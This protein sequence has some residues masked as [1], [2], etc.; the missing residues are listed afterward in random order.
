MSTPVAVVPERRIVSTD[1]HVERRGEKRL[2]VISGYAARFNELAPEQWGFR[3]K[4]DPT[5]F[6]D[7]LASP[8]TDV[9][10]FFNHDNN[11]IVGRQSA[12][13]LRLSV[14]AKGLRYEIDPPD[15]QAGRDLVVSVE[16]GDVREASFSFVLA[17]HDGDSWDETQVPPV[18]TLRKAARVY[19]VGPVCFPWYPTASAE[20]QRTTEMYAER[21]AAARPKQNTEAA[22]TGQPATSSQAGPDPAIAVARSRLDL[23][24]KE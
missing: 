8:E 4:I 13:T 15:T 2:P 14:D 22:P 10:A 24:E 18:R 3:E 21:R 6:D 19:D 16:R 5:F 17:E 1:V 20:V 9:R 23:A 7:V 11:L 12:G